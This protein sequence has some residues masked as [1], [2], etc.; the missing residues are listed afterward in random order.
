MTTSQS[1]TKDPHTLFLH[2][3][4]MLH[5]YAPQNSPLSEERTRTNLRITELMS[6]YVQETFHED[7]VELGLA[8]YRV[9]ADFA[10]YLAY[11]DY[12]QK[13]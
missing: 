11:T 13:S 5:N 2:S 7:G 1:R 4:G 8:A 12:D 6:D 3:I 10:R 9:L